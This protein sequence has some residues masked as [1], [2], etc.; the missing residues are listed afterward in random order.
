MQRSSESKYLLKKGRSGAPVFLFS[1]DGDYYRAKGVTYSLKNNYS[2]AALFFQK[3]IEI[4][5]EAPQNHFNL[6]C[7][8]SKTGQLAEANSIF[9]TILKTIDP[10]MY[11]CYFYMAVNYAVLDDLDQTRFCLHKYIDYNPSGEFFDDAEEFL[12]VLEEE[13]NALLPET[14]SK[15][16]EDNLLHTVGRYDHEEFKNLLV[17]STNY[18]MKLKKGLFQG[19]DLLREAIIKKLGTVK[20]KEALD[21]LL[22]FVANP[23]VSER[24]RQLALSTIKKFSL[25]E[26]LLVY[27]YMNGFRRIK[28]EEHSLLAP[29]WKNSW[30][31]VLD[32]TYLNM[33]KRGYYSKDFFEDAEAIWL[34]L[35]NCLYPGGP[36]VSK[37]QTWAAALEY[38]LSRF[39]FLGLT[40]AGLAADYGVSSS[41][42]QKRFMEINRVLN[43]ERK[44]SQNMQSLLDKRQGD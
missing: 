42:V 39:H 22:E 9:W 29:L 41:S 38:S 4:E 23:W 14:I 11:D 21:E 18:R 40:Q 3:A 5:P 6:A 19:G 32:C 26:S 30:Q 12:I 16:E 13:R 36:R 37:P 35:I 34:D 15:A 25:A 1:R 7:L 28:S 31:K 20:A 44:A 33:K 17:T 8:L 43:I 27:D 2:R 24:L 10:E